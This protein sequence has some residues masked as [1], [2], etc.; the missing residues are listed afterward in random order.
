MSATLTSTPAADGYRMPAEW[1]DHAGCFLVWP[2]RTDN[3]RDGAK[4]AQ[5]AWRAL[6]ET[7]ASAEDVTVLVSY[8][9]YAVARGLLPDHVRLVEMTTNDAWVR[10]TGPSFVVDDEG[11]VRGVSW[12]FNA[13]GGLR[14]GLY[15]P[16]DAD[17]QVGPKICDLQRVPV[18]QPS[19]V[20]EGGSIDVDGEGTLLTTEECLLNPNRNPDLSR[21]QIEAELHA[22]LG[23]T[24]AIWLPRGVVD[25]ETDGHIDNFAR[26]AAPGV[27]MLTW[28]DDESD[29][30]HE[31]SA[32]ALAI[33]EK[34]TDARGRPL[35][36]VKLLQPGPLR[37]TAEEADG[38]DR[39]PG[40]QPRTAGERLAGSYVNSYIGNGIV[41]LPVFDDPNDA[42][43]VAAYEELF[44]G[45]RVLT[46]PG[47]DI[48]LGGGNVHCI[49]QQLP[50]GR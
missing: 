9:Q 26:F 46:V 6:I 32:E 44:P 36:V 47:R 8:Q 27:V 23:T 30:Q 7:I 21:E 37:M 13:W 49:T 16:W 2:E 1:D 18:Y 43:A 41:V 28:T 39:V 5:R 14:G 10:D 20:L 31:R 15:F 35:R 22:H 29:P 48:L 4:P 24:K 42:A 38:V 3:W 17:D 33:L 19:L 25:D 12:A 45:R 34:E 50:S 40:S 11:D